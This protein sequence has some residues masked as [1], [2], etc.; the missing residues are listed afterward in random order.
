MAGQPK[1]RP[2]VQAVRQW[3]GAEGGSALILV[4][5]ILLVLTAV[6][7][8]ALRDVARTVQQSGVY[9]VR[10]QSETFTGSVSEFVSERAGTYAKDYWNEMQ[11]GLE[12]DMGVATGT[13]RDAR[14][15]M[16][17]MMTLS[18]DTGSTGEMGMLGNSTAE[19]GL[20]YE[21]SVSK[22]SFEQAPNE[23]THDFSVILRDPMDGIPVPGYSSQFCFKKITIATDATVGQADD[24]WKKANM[25]ASTQSGSEVLIGPLDC[26]GGS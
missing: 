5:L 8:V 6:G 15:D 2:D 26:G 10:A 23:D 21:D 20:F 16:G 13:E 3:L 17:A 19:T 18:Q 12:N 7:M 24:E 14:N 11:K 4:M 9:R 1:Y 25:V 22:A